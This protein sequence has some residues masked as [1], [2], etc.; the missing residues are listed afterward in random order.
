M[1]LQCMSV[2][3][4]IVHYYGVFFF[5][6]FFL[7]LVIM[8]G[9]VIPSQYRLILISLNMNIKSSHQ[10]LISMLILI[11]C[12]SGE[13]LARDYSMMH[14]S[15]GYV[16]MGT[17]IENGLYCTCIVACLTAEENCFVKLIT[18]YENG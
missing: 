7:S 3:L 13:W 1:Q 16:G 18:K 14:G 12:C 5:Y 2:K 6:T 9:N 15:W 10:A 11:L 4:W 8:V 17:Y